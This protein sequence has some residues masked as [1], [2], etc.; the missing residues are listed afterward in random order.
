MKS[1]KTEQVRNDDATT[2]TAIARF[3]GYGAIA[4]SLMIATAVSAA[5]WITL[6]QNCCSLLEGGP[7]MTRK[8]STHSSDLLASSVRLACMLASAPSLPE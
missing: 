1:N 8:C 4:L 7:N 5:C 3:L 2:S 6:D